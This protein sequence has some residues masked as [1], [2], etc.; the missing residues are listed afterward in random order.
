MTRLHSESI[1]GSTL[2]PAAW[3]AEGF[4]TAQADHQGITESLTRAYAANGKAAQGHR[5]R[6]GGWDKDAAYAPQ[7][8]AAKG[9]A[10]R[11]SI[12]NRPQSPFHAVDSRRR[13]KLKIL[14]VIETHP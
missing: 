2:A 6:G 13:Q 10:V 1:P 11:P 7:G 5:R 3:V 4:G 14:R 9:A 8:R 12:G